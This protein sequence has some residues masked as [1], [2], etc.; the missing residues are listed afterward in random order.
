VLNFSPA[1]QQTG[2]NKLIKKRGCWY[3]KSQVQ[4]QVKLKVHF[5]KR[6]ELVPWHARASSAPSKGWQ[7]APSLQGA[8]LALGSE[9][10]ALQVVPFNQDLV[11]HGPVLR[12][13]RHW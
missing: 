9:C 3:G 2:D 11:K 5:W 1:L 12:K 8:D 7:Q 10:F 6:A 13:S 4:K